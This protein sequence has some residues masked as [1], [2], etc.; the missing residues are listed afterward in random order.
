MAENVPVRGLQRG[1]LSKHTGCHLETIRYYE[2]IG[3]MPEPPRSPKGYRLYGETHLR[4]LRFILRSRELG[5]GIDE[6][7]GLLD[8]VDRKCQTC[9]EVQERTKPHLAEV[10]AKIADLR[11]IER[12]LSQTM[13]QCSGE[14]VPECPIIDALA[15]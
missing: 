15:A 3:L 13:A 11:R 2:N 12:L 6:I 5:F 14:A 7:R 1:Q 10:R 8:L 4:R 9:S